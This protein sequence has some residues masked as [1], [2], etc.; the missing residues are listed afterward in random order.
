M[1]SNRFWQIRQQCVWKI[2]FQ[3]LDHD[4]LGPLIWL[5]ILFYIL[6][7]QVNSC[8]SWAMQYIVISDFFR[9]ILQEFQLL[10]MHKLKFGHQKYPPF[11]SCCTPWQHGD[12]R[13]LPHPPFATS[14]ESMAGGL[15]PVPHEHRIFDGTPGLF[16]APW[17][18]HGD[19]MIKNSGSC[20]PYGCFQK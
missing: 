19:I 18:T 3:H 9:H 12:G 4:Q 8:T 15:T 10:H 13:S 5:E 17:D 11:G 2:K 14:A 7:L 16:W 6:L 20:Y 1:P